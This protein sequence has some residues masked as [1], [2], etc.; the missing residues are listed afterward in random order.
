M[1]ISRWIACGLLA[2]SIIVGGCQKSEEMPKLNGGEAATPTSTANPSN[3]VQP[4]PRHPQVQLSNLKFGK[5][6]NNRETISVDWKLPPG[7]EGS[8]WT[9]VIKPSSGGNRMELT[10]WFRGQSGTISGEVQTFGFG[11]PGSSPSLESGCEVYLVENK[12]D[13]EFKIS[14]SL[15]SGTAQVTQA[16]PATQAELAKLKR[17]LA[18]GPPEN[19]GTVPLS[20]N[21]LLPPETPIKVSVG[22]SWVDA[23]VVSQ[24]RAGGLVMVRRSDMK[25]DTVAS[26]D[27]VR[28][29]PK[30]LKAIPK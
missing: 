3:L 17:E 7:A 13:L 27:S 29:D 25:V 24:S 10:D 22:R 11:R 30:V 5:T 15:T 16:R 9:L 4:L 6:F 14:N 8:Q 18:A 2:V 26:P 19:S 28:I 1:L 12:G 20:K 23:K 21:V